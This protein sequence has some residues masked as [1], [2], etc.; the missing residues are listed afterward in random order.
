MLKTICVIPTYNEKDNILT[1]IEQLQALYP[2]LHILVVDDNSPDGTGAIVEQMKNVK[3]DVL[4][5]EYKEGLGS[6]YLAG[7]KK[8]LSEGADIIIQMD[9][10]LSHEPV[11]IK[12][13]L[14]KIKD[15]DVVIG[16]RYLNGISIVNWQLSRLILSWFGNAY[17]RFA[18]GIK[19]N[20]LTGGF[21]CMRRK[22]LEV[23]DLR[24]IKTQGYGF[25]IEMNYAFSKCG[26]KISE[27][28]IIFYERTK[29]KSKISK[30]MVLEAMIKVFFFRFKNYA[31]KTKLSTKA[32]FV[33]GPL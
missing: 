8:A 22:A 27:L 28:P 12:A 23:I 1:L 16:S 10:D 7:F 14:E 24:R 3:I 19:I 5:R 15:H 25:Q 13:M 20:D 30:F 32:M 26:L 29:G 6:A 17:A 31:T 9:A 18:T 21:K 4:H 2:E 11:Y 33:K